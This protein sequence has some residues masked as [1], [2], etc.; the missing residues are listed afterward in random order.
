MLAVVARMTRDGKTI[1]E[2]RKF[3]TSGLLAA[4]EAPSRQESLLRKQVEEINE[5]LSAAM[6]E[7]ERSQA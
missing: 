2:K 7:H 4:A 3:G 6:K 1:Y 5:A